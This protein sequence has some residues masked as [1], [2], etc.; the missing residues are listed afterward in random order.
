MTKILAVISVVVVSIAFLIALFLMSSS[1]GN[2]ASDSTPVDIRVERR[3]EASITSQTTTKIPSYTSSSSV[4]QTSSA[5][6]GIVCKPLF[7][8]NTLYLNDDELTIDID[9]RANVEPG[10]IVYVNEVFI[11]D[12]T[13]GSNITL[14]KSPTS[15]GGGQGLQVALDPIR[16]S[17]TQY[18]DLKENY[19]KKYLIYIIYVVQYGGVEET[20]S[21]PVM[22]RDLSPIS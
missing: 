12:T 4:E 21:I 20:C 8:V 5:S 14:L 7:Y 1:A 18:Y 2:R 22:P 10:C 11:V 9:L 16:L 6:P 17:P 19:E 3:S 15:I 13:S